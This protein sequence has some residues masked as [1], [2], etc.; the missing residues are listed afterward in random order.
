MPERSSKRKKKETDFTVTAFRVVQEATGQSEQPK[1]KE[2]EPPT[3][4]KN[5][6]AV[7]LGRMGGKAGGRARAQSLT[8]EQRSEIAKKAAAKRW[9]ASAKG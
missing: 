7:A 9:G 8:P 5:P 1:A 2:P 3:E 4:G 6:H